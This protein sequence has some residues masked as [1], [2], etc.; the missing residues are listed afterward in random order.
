[1]TKTPGGNKDGAF[2]LTE[3]AALSQTPGP[4]KNFSMSVD[5]STARKTSAIVGGP[6]DLSPSQL[7]ASAGGFPY[8]GNLDDLIA[9][10]R[11]RALNQTA[12]QKEIVALNY[13]LEKQRV[14]DLQKKLEQK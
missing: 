8:S 6:L 13:A 9:T 3:N 14:K 5:K 4:K 12:K 10:E 1:M 11:K 7:N 2:F